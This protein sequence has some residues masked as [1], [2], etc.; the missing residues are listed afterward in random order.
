[1]KHLFFIPILLLASNCMTA[2]SRENSDSVETYTQLFFD[3]DF[4]ALIEKMDTAMLNRVKGGEGLSDFHKEVISFVGNDLIFESMQRDTADGVILSK[5]TARGKEGIAIEITWAY[6]KDGLIK[7][8]SIR[9]KSTEAPS[10][11]L[12]YHSKTHLRLPFDGTWTIFAGGRTLAT[13]HHAVAKNQRFAL[14]IAIAKEGKTHINEGKLLTDYYV[15]GKEVLAP[16]EGRV[17][18]LADGL[19]D[20]EMGTTD[21]ENVAGN[22]LVIDHGNGEYSFLAHFQNGSFEVKEGDAVKA[23]QVLGRV[24]NSGNTTE[25]HLHY[26]LQDGGNFP[27]SECM[28]ATFYNYIADGK[29]VESGEPIQGQQVSNK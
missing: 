19:P 17:V 25:P 1:M 26:H 11:Y 21:K 18:V 20:N 7:G 24:G 5:Q 9:P 15:W 16:A 8:F 23:G 4:E 22:Y 2:Q 14:D 3:Q 27:Q 12:D 28:P 13:N 29:L 6:T 10:N